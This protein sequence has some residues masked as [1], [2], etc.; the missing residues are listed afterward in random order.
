MQVWDFLHP[1]L[2]EYFIQELGD[3][4]TKMIMSEYRSQLTQFRR[5]TKMRELLGWFGNISETSMFQI[6]ML[7][8]GDN[9]KEKTYKDFEV[10][11]VSLLC[12]V[13]FQSSL[14]LC[15]VLTGSVLVALAIPNSIPVRTIERMISERSFLTFLVENEISAVYAEGVCLIRDINVH[16]TTYI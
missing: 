15:G 7:S 4:E 6:V 12:R 11:R 8:L 10:L 3:I 1:Q 5:T 2:L 13:F 14:H 9:W 16:G